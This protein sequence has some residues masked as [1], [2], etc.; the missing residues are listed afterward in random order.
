MQSYLI[1][2]RQEGVFRYKP[3]HTS[4]SEKE[5]HKIERKYTIMKRKLLYYVTLALLSLPLFA[6]NMGQLHATTPSLR[7]TEESISFDLG[8]EATTIILIISAEGKVTGEGVEGEIEANGGFV[9]LNVKNNHVVLHG[10]ITEFQCSTNEIT[11]L[12]VSKAP[13][14]KLLECSGNPIGTLD[15]SANKALEVLRCNKCA[16]KELVP[17]TTLKELSCEDNAISELD[18]SALTSLNELKI[19]RNKISTLNLTACT[20]LKKLY[21]SDNKL[22]ELDITKNKNLVYINCYRN[23]INGIDVRQCADLET[24][25]C[26]Y[27]SFNTLDVTQNKKLLYLWCPSLHLTSLDIT[28]NTALEH[29]LFFLNDLSQIDTSKNPALKELDCSE[30]KL[31]SLDVSHNPELTAISCNG[32]FIDLQQMDAFIKSMPNQQGK[33]KGNL[34]VIDSKNPKEKNH[35]S[36]TNV[37]AAKAKNWVVWDYNGNY[38]TS[39]PYEGET[40]NQSVAT[41]HVRISP[42]PASGYVYIS[43]SKPNASIY[44]YSMKGTLIQ[45]SH[46]DANGAAEINLS[47]VSKGNYLLKSDGMSEILIVE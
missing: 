47:G 32:N 24:L 13:S 42:N 18:V 23:T 36:T 11:A 38:A 46:T 2:E 4:E 35:C 8:G 33:E 12:D 21:C 17:P 39:R 41:L 45:T 7:E 10:K 43:G 9:F 14:L 19:S 30:N 1:E 44:L 29:L 26:G 27:N 20:D 16:L 6:T 37:K 15:L 25:Y 28:Q 5:I 22:P 40:A 34:Y 31:T 3:T